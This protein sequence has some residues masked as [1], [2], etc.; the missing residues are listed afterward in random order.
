MG[1]RSPVK[2][3]PIELDKQRH[4]RMDWNAMYLAEESISKRSPGKWVSIQSFTDLTKVSVADI[5]SLIWASLV[6]EDK[7]LTE[8]DVGR[9]IHAGNQE[10]VCE[11]L[12]KAMEA[13]ASTN[14]DGAGPLA[15][16]DG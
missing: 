11:C 7:D 5:R 14:G 15:K 3:I 10:Y 8:W 2:E 9:M 16:G 12:V 6:H 1:G 4:M 13:G